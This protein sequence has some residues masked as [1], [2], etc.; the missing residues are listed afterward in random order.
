MGD[1]AC[2]LVAFPMGTAFPCGVGKI[3]QYGESAVAWSWGINGVFSVVGILLAEIVAME[4]GYSML[5][6]GAALCYVLAL[7]VYRYL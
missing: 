5:L 2:P 4:F 6:G 3:R 7:V 1:S